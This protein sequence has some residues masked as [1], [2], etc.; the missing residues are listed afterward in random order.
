MAG[1]IPKSVLILIRF[2]PEPQHHLAVRIYGSLHAS[3]LHF[4]MTLTITSPS[5]GQSLCAVHSRLV[6]PQQ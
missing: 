2:P 5:G 4:L 3:A 6:H 1:W